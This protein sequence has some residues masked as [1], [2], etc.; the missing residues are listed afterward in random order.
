M[1]ARFQICTIWQ[2][3][4]ILGQIF[5]EIFFRDG[6]V[7]GCGQSWMGFPNCWERVGEVYQLLG[8]KSECTNV[9]HAH[10]I[11]FIMGARGRGMR[12]GGVRIYC[13]EMMDLEITHPNSTLLESRKVCMKLF[14]SSECFCS[15]VSTLN[16]GFFFIVYLQVS[17]RL[18]N[19]GTHLRSTSGLEGTPPGVLTLTGSDRVPSPFLVSAAT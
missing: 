8:V 13:I 11:N 14:L 10:R 18:K 6:I 4:N 19:R 9:R 16:H 3:A 12:G 2:R 15:L 17:L 7:L 5:S 1:V